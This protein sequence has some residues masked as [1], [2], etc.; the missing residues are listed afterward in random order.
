MP[1]QIKLFNTSTRSIDPLTPR[2]P[3]KIGIYCCGPT[4]YNFQHIGN[5]KT[6]IFEDVLVRTLRRAGYEVLHVM[7]ITDVGHLVSDGDEGEDK[8]MVA[9]RREKKSSAEIAQYYTEVFLDDCDKLHVKRPD[10]IC[11]ATDHIQEMI[12]MNQAI[13]RN[14]Y[15]YFANGNLYFD[16]SKFPE[17]GRLALLDLEKLKAGARIEVD[18]NK[19]SPFDF[20]LWFTNSKFENQELQWDS[21]WGRGYPGWH[22]ECSAMAQ[23]YLGDQFDIHCG[24]I[25]H[26]PVHHTNEIAQTEAATGKKPSVSVWMHSDFMV[27]NKQKMSKSTGGFLTLTD[28]INDNVPADAYRYFCLTASYR[29]QLNFSRDALDSAI[30]S[31]KRLRNGVLRLLEEG[32]SQE[33]LGA[34]ATEH[35]ARFNEALFNDLNTPQAL[36]ALWGALGDKD[37]SASQRYSLLL[38]FDTIFGLDMGN[39][40]QSEAEIP[41]EIQELLNSRIKA[42]AEKNWAESDRLRDEITSRGFTVLDSKDGMKVTRT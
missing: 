12:A 11:K 17:Y 3:G 6:Y 18:Q 24:G 25:D 9:M 29:S 30:E 1:E 37:L 2:V 13:E 31:V 7:N 39:W 22:I 40:K 23:K 21:P 32:A 36:A 34:R 19:R 38:D 35:K 10:V 5:L 20:V 14:G 27:I 28:L 33:A 4:V 26:I 8:M 42:R 16:V 15:A 41:H